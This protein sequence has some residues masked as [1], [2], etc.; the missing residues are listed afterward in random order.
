MWFLNECEN[1]NSV[2]WYT[3]S[4]F[5]VPVTP[6]FSSLVP[7]PTMLSTPASPQPYHMKPLGMS[8]IQ[9]SW[10]Y[11]FFALHI[12]HFTSVFCMDNECLSFNILSQYFLPG[13]SFPNNVIPSV[14]STFSYK[15]L[16][17]IYVHFV[18]LPGWFEWALS[19]QAIY[20]MPRT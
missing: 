3:K 17:H 12:M 9:A 14:L 10:F 1:S 2:A 4:L 20:I 15:S 11:S 8:Y 13:R 18:Y 19:W 5:D 16:R 7:L 6:P